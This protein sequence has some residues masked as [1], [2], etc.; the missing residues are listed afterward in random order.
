MCIRDRYQRRVHG[1][2]I[3][4]SDDLQREASYVTFER[5]SLLQFSNNQIEILPILDWTTLQIMINNP[6]TISEEIR[7]Y[8]SIC[9]HTHKV[10]FPRERL[11][12]NPKRPVPNH[13]SPSITPKPI[14]NPQ[15]SYFT[16]PPSFIS[17]NQPLSIV[18]SHTVWKSHQ[19]YLQL[20][21]SKLRKS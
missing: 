6:Y 5:T 13:I 10:F 4:A 15:Q 8:Q 7:Y 1:E 3:K 21:I 11:T 18:L 17:L 16:S 20:R 12:K 19:S 14:S 9:L 2:V